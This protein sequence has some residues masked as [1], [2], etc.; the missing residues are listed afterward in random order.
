MSF[1]QG[2]RPG[3]QEEQ[4]QLGQFQRHVVGGGGNHL[5]GRR[6]RVRRWFNGP[7]DPLQ[8]EEFRLESARKFVG[9]KIGGPGSRGGW[10]QLGQFQGHVVGGGG[11]NLGGRRGGVRRGVNGPGDHPLKRNT[12]QDCN[13]PPP[14]QVVTRL[15]PP[16]ATCRWNWPNWPYPR[17]KVRAGG[18]VTC[19]RAPWTDVSR[20]EGAGLGMLRPTVPCWPRHR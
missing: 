1:R 6:G 19:G 4:G 7:T 20:R 18:G 15:P 16:P 13:P 8:R 11:K 3:E 5:G 9:A 14:T 2:W 17:G 12:G 10:G